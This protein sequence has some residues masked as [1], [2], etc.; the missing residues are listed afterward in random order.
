MAELILPLCSIQIVLL[1]YTVLIQHAGFYGFGQ[2]EA[3]IGN[4]AMAT[5]A[6]LFECL[7]QTTSFVGMPLAKAS[8]GAFLLRLVSS[9]WHQVAVWGA[10]ILM[11][12]A[13]VGMWNPLSVF[14]EIC[15]TI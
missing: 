13:S 3:E 2:T 7:A 9:T 8:L 14:H 4:S 10:M 1:A 5:K 12:L 6:R 15:E 11:S